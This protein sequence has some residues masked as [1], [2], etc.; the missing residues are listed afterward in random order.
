MNSIQSKFID[1]VKLYC[2]KNICYTSIDDNVFLSIKNQE[3]VIYTN[4]TAISDRQKGVWN[5]VGGSLGL[6][7]IFHQYPHYDEKRIEM[8]RHNFNIL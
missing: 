1:A 7:L 2:D 6:D 4:I 5:R 8:D 3:S